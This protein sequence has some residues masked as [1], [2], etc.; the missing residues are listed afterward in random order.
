MF[1]FTYGACG[2]TN[3]VLTNG[4]FTSGGT[5]WTVTGAWTYSFGWANSPV[6]GGG[7]IQQAIALT[8]FVQLTFGLEVNVGSMIL[9]SNLG[10]IDF[11]TFGGQK[12]VVFDATGMTNLNF[13]FGSANGGRIQN[14]IVRPISS[15]VRIAG[16]DANGDFI[17][18]IDPP[19]SKVITD[20]FITFALDWIDPPPF[21]CYSFA[22]Y[23]PCQCSQFGFI[24]DDF[25]TPNQFVVSVGG[26]G[27][28]DVSGG[29]MTV[30]NSGVSAVTVLR[31]DVLCVGVEY[32]ITYTLSGMAVG[33]TFRLASGTA[34]GILRNA[35]GTYTETLTVTATNDLPQDLRFVFAFVGG[36]HA[37]TL[38]E[39]SIEASEPII[40]YQSV[41]FEFTDTLNCNNCTVLVEACGNGNQLNF[42]FDGSGFKPSIRIEGTLRGTGY[43]STRTQY[44]FATGKRVVPYAR[45]R[46]ARSLLFG[47]PEYVHDFMQTLIALDNVYINGRLSH[48]EDDEYPTPSL[49]ADVDFAT[50]TMTFSDKTELTEKRPC[51]ATAD[52]GCETGGF[53]VTFS[54]TGGLSWGGGVS[55]KAEA[56]NGL[57]LTYNG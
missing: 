49:E 3:N 20:G 41:Q 30:T 32:D 31:K 8:G 17:Y 7:N 27:N 42:G 50:V 1:Q 14:V 29:E 12:S 11:Y 38:D 15:D 44:E 9:S 39:F 13:F 2:N 52:I 10:L 54:G 37:V 35:D 34:N 28:V 23:D 46:K 24:G 43:P 40:T 36:L 45:L 19:A 4:D 16:L 26:A 5:G 18:F 47:A 56:I 25:D 53:G 55:N 33:D 6:G 57:I 48:C 21:G 51:A 22:V